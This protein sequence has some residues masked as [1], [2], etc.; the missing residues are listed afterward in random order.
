MSLVCN[1]FSA[2]CECS[3]TLMNE[4]RRE[5]R[6]KRENYLLLAKVERS[7]APS[8][9]TIA[10]T[11]LFEWFECSALF[12]THKVK[13]KLCEKSEQL[14]LNESE[15]RLERRGGKFCTFEPGLCAPVNK[16]QHIAMKSSRDPRA[17]G[18]L[19]AHRVRENVTIHLNLLSE[20]MKNFK[21]KW[22]WGELTNELE[23]MEFQFSW[24]NHRPPSLFARVVQER[25][26][27]TF[28]SDNF[29]QN[30]KIKSFKVTTPSKWYTICNKNSTDSVSSC[31]NKLTKH[32]KQKSENIIKR[33]IEIK[34]NLG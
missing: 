28:F 17:V 25:I 34:K 32:V 12:P 33:M 19:S 23:L 29:L 2:L 15:R 7:R 31:A 3:N 1:F 8:L 21:W 14:A 20:S 22:K 30:K 18:Q 11:R 13:W 4:W 26:W 16:T 9:L 24:H 10:H 5:T 6:K 27:S